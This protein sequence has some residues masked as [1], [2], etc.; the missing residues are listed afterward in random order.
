VLGCFLASVGYDVLFAANG[1]EAL[2]LLEHGVRPSLI[3]LDLRMPVMDGISF[4]SRQQE[5]G[6]ANIPVLLLSCEQNLAE[7]AAQLGVEAYVAKP[8]DAEHLLRVVA[9]CLP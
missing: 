6:W 9:K 8:F 7:A 3:L 2:Q 5:L 4:R 1:A